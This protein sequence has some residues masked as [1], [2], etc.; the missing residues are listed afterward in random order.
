[1]WKSSWAPHHTF[2]L[3]K[4]PLDFALGAWGLDD[5]I[6]G[7]VLGPRLLGA[8]S[9]DFKKSQGAGSADF[10]K[11]QG[12][13]AFFLYIYIYIYINMQNVESIAK[14]MKT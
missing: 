6:C 12:A 9:A 5:G 11:S 14:N 8:G 13:G 2:G 1:M 3:V 7:F 4:T 10:Q